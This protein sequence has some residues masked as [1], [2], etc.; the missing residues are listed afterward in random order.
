MKLAS[1]KSGRDG[2][3]MIVD[4]GLQR[5]C[6]AGDLAPT[7]QTALDDWSNIAP[8]LQERYEHLCEGTLDASSAFEPGKCAAPLPRSYHWADGS[9]YVTHVELVRKAR[10]A[11]MP[12]SFWEDPLVYMGASDAFIGPEDPVTAESE[13]WGIDFEGEVVVVT[14]DVAAGTTADEAAKHIKLLGIVNDVSLRN[15]I[16]GELAKQFG[17]YQSKPWTAFAPVFVTPDELGT[18]WDGARLHLPLRATLNGELI[19]APN[20]GQDMTFDFPTLIAHCAK[21][22]SLISGTVIGSGT[23]SNVGSKDGSCCLAEVRCLETLRDG[24]PSTPFMSFGDRIHIEMLDGEGAS[25]FGAIDQ[26]IR[27]FERSTV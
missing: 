23:V 14:D 5:C 27:P 7:M 8:R 15:L 24:K 9:A 19:G 11:D 1:Y 16:P 12:T 17:F 3:L 26:Q 20:A 6:P 25:V 10:G 18:A 21:S 22:R 13:D 2:Q 4:R